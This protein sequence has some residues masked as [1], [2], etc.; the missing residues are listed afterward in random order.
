MLLWEA[1]AK[2]ILSMSVFHE[3]MKLCPN[4]GDGEEVRQEREM[5]AMDAF[6]PL[7]NSLRDCMG[8]SWR[9][10]FTKR[11]FPPYNVL[12]RFKE[13]A[14]IHRRFGPVNSGTSPRLP[15][16]SGLWLR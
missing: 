16:E 8:T 11:S 14:R 9:V 4:G 6:A 2:A 3:R 1:R 7:Y 10:A 5:K 15:R 13:E 12:P